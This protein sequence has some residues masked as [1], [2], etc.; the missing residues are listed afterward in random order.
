MEDLGV[1]MKPAR[2]TT[3]TRHNPRAAEAA[4]VTKK[5]INPFLTTSVTT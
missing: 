1:I 3:I 5:S 2:A 4:A